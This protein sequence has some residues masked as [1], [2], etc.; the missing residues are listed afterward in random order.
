[1]LKI[2]TNFAPKRP[3]IEKSFSFFIQMAWIKT[4]QKSEI[5]RNHAESWYLKSVGGTCFGYFLKMFRF[6]LKFEPNFTKNYQ[7]SDESGK[8]Y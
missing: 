8:I 7:I 1:M 2:L 4:S 5:W 3:K 6:C